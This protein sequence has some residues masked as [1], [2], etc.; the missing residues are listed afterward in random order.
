V[1]ILAHGF[2]PPI[3][4]VHFDDAETWANGATSGTIDLESIA[5][6]EIGHALGLAHTPVSAA[7]MF[8]TFAGGTTKV[9]LTQDD[10]D[11]MRS[12]YGP[13]WSFSW[14]SGGPIPG[15]ACTQIREPSDPD[16][17]HD[18]FFCSDVPT[19]MAWS[20]GGALSA[21]LWN[22]TK[23]DEPSDPNT[24]G[25]NFLCLPKF[26]PPPPG[27][28]APFTWSFSGPLVGKTCVQWFEFSDANNWHDNFLCR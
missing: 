7:V 6:H 11:G 17:W 21:A 2:F 13:T 15:K 3:G 23:I 1:N 9:G 5:V 18:N 16:S 27:F 12:L 26:P 19:G 8:A 20:N 25:D 24:W 4:M 10:I 22:C 14:S 28:N